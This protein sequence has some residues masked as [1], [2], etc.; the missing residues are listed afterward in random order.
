[1]GYGASFFNCDD[2]KYL[3]NFNINFNEGV[4]NTLFGFITGICLASFIWIVVASI[5][6]AKS[7]EYDTAGLI[8]VIEA[9]ADAKPVVLTREQ[10]HAILKDLWEGEQ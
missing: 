6:H 8:K 2:Y 3:C 1:L 7:G 9:N 4:M 5:D 10:Q